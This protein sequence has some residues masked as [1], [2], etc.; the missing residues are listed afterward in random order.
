MTY[1]LAK[2]LWEH[3]FPQKDAMFY[4]IEDRRKQ[5][6]ADGTWKPR[7][8][9]SKEANRILSSNVF[10][11]AAPTLEELIEACG[12]RFDKL[13]QSEKVASFKQQWEATGDEYFNGVAYT[14]TEAV[15]RLWLALKANRPTV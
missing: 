15:A 12:E 13:E 9:S 11:Y 7:L 14:P 3:F 10:R 6:K 2:E 1:E 8:I 5:P 4:W